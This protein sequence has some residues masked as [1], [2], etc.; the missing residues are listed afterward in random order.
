MDDV[1]PVGAL[2]KMIVTRTPRSIAVTYHRSVKKSEKWQH[3]RR[4]EVG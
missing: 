3:P 2:R 1:L 4:R